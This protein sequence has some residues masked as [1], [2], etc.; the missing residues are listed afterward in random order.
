[1][2]QR[3]QDYH[4]QTVLLMFLTHLADIIVQ[5]TARDQDDLAA[6]EFLH[7]VCA[8]AGARYSTQ[9]CPSLVPKPTASEAGCC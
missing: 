9:A 5:V 2:H 8:A 1:M 6:E 7:R 3:N 4:S